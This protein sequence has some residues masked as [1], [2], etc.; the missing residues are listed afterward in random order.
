MHIIIT[1]TLTDNGP[2][3]KLQRHLP[4]THKDKIHKQTLTLCDEFA[5]QIVYTRP[6]RS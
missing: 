4:S 6:R 2:L 5:M 3:W 1:I